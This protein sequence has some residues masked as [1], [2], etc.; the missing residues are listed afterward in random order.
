[1]I[2]YNVTIT[3]D[4]EVEPQ[5]LQW[6]QEV[7]IPDVLRTGCF[8]EAR[9]LRLLHM[10]EPGQ[11]TYAVQYRCRDLRDLARYEENYADRLRREHTEKFKDKFV[12]FRTVLEERA[13]FDKKQSV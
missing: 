7:H 5:W 1:M 11:C 9:L 4:A 3:V 13:S 6:M 8:E 10:D 12:A 2:L